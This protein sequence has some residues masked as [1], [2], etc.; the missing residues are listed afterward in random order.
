ME[1]SIFIN[2]SKISLK[3]LA[4]EQDNAFKFQALRF[5]RTY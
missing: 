1:L 4:L 2:F 3:M 5:T